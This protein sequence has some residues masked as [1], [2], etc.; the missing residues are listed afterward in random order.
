MFGALGLRLRASSFRDTSLTHHFQPTN[1]YYQ[2]IYNT[3]NGLIIRFDTLSPGEARKKKYENFWPGARLA[4]PELRL[5]SDVVSLEYAQQVTTYGHN[6]KNFRY[7]IN[8]SVVN[9]DTWAIIDL[10]LQRK[11]LGTPDGRGHVRAPLW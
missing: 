3:L 9:E 2:L 6:A 11:G 5:L 7:V 10:I 8:S 1:A 4:L